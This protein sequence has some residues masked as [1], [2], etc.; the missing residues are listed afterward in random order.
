MG[1]WSPGP[2]PTD[3]ADVFTGDE[4]NETADGGFGN[5]TLNGGGGDDTL[6]GACGE[7]LMV[8]ADGDRVHPASADL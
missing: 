5:D 1:V 4:T 6:D 7:Y 3:G 2:G 8:L